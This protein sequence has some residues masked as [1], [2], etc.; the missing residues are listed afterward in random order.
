MVAR[1]IAVS[2]K[3]PKNPHPY[4][5][6]EYMGRGKEGKLPYLDIRQ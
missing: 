1:A 3:H 6:P 2:T 4:P 5:P